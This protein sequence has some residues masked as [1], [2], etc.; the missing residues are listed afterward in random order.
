MKR[1][2]GERRPQLLVGNGAEFKYLGGHC[3]SLEEVR[4]GG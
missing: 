4:F 1:R 2:V 3:R